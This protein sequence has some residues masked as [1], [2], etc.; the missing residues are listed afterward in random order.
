MAPPVT[1]LE[2]TVTMP[3][4]ALLTEML[5]LTLPPVTV[6]DVMVT[7]PVLLLLRP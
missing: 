5:L 1:V 4:L 7:A 6:L 3:V 2:M